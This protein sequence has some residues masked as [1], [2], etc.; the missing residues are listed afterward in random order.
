[1]CCPGR[2]CLFLVSRG[3]GINN[4]FCVCVRTYSIPNALSRERQRVRESKFVYACV[5]GGW[6]GERAR[7]RAR[8]LKSEKE[9][10][11]ESNKGGA[12]ES[13]AVERELFEGQPFF[14]GL[15]ILTSYQHRFCVNYSATH[16]NIL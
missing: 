15:Q 11:R 3:G 8:E 16:C 1:M 13:E 14:E 4:C 2:V 6:G 12:R 9:S 5:G 7:V 10:A